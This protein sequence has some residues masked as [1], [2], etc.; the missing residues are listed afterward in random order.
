MGM[1]P[2][3]KDT[4]TDDIHLEAFWLYHHSSQTWQISTIS[5]KDYLLAVCF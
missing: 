2:F 3:C 4:K 1:I 5:R